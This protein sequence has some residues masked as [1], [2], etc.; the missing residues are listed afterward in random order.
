MT[1][2]E[3]AVERLLESALP[4]LMARVVAFA[5]EVPKEASLRFLPCFE[6]GPC[7][8]LPDGFRRG[9]A[10]A[11]NFEADTTLGLDVLVA[12]E[13]PVVTEVGI[14]G[15]GIAS[16]RVV[17]LFSGCFSVLELLR[18]H[19]R[20][21]FLLSELIEEGVCGS[22]GLGCCTGDF[23]VDLV[24]T[25]DTVSLGIAVEGCRCA[26]GPD[27]FD[28]ATVALVP[29]SESRISLPVCDRLK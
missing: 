10:S 16:W 21:S 26:R 1:E 29:S 3:L 12:I 8:S 22:S 6:T 17:L 4:P 5:T 20:L 9:S 27:G 14:R 18:F 15:A 23:G 2:V 11:L 25:L 24:K 13:L 19:D 28:C 7:K